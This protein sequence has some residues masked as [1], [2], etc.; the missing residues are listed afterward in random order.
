MSFVVDRH[1]AMYSVSSKVGGDKAS[2]VELWVQ[3]GEQCDLF[4]TSV[5]KKHFP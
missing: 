1:N 4:Q 3:S 5:F 2:I